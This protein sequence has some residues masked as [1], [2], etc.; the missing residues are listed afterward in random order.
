MTLNSGSSPVL[1]LQVYATT[2]SF[3]LCWDQ[4]QAFARQAFYQLSRIHCLQLCDNCFTLTL[5][6]YHLK[7]IIVS[8]HNGGIF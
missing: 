6:Q 4:T 7:V 8:P 3:I 2:H 1:E 5:P